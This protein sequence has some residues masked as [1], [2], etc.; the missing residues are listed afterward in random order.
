MLN[1]RAVVFAVVV[2]CLLSVQ[3]TPVLAAPRVPSSPAD[4]ASFRATERTAA[5]N[6][7]WRL[8][9]ELLVSGRA[10]VHSVTSTMDG[11]I[12]T[13]ERVGPRNPWPGRKAAAATASFTAYCQVRWT[14]TTSG[15]W[16]HGFVYIDTPWIAFDIYAG[17]GG[18]PNQ[19]IRDG[20]VLQTFT[21]HGANTDLVSNK[22]SDNFKWW[23]EHPTYV[24][25]S[26]MGI[27]RYRYGSWQLGPDAYCRAEGS[28]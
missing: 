10:V 27:Q 6:H 8:Y 13:R 20:V 11:T 7:Q 22:S 1:S 12:R 18:K 3:V 17:R 4:W 21:A 16:T 26:W 28:P 23:Y 19:F 14:N 5:L 25:R 15:S 24:I 9:Q 2:A